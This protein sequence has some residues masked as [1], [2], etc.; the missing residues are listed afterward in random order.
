MIAIIFCISILLFSSV[1]LVSS[2]RYSAI[3]NTFISLNYSLPNTWVELEPEGYSQ[4]MYDRDKVESTTISYVK[5]NLKSHFESV[6]V[7]FYY[8]DSETLK[9]LDTR[10]IT[11]VRISLKADITPFR[12][13]SR[14]MSYSIIKKD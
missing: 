3:D 2:T 9:E 4:P 14:A 13:Y 7:G 10:Y 8:F 5:N 6:K 11:G 1:S 12:K